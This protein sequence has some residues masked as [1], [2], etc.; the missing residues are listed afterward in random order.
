MIKHFS[1]W[2]KLVPL[3]NCNNEG[4]IYVFLDKM[5][6]QFGALVEILI[7]QGMKF[8]GEFQKWCQKTLINYHDFTKPS[9][10]RWVN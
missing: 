1:K 9:L 6:N 10:N 8:C 5:F 2:L 7:D 3:P 4:I